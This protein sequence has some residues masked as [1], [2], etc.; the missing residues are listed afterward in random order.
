M[1]GIDSALAPLVS[2][3]VDLRDFEF[4][5]LDVVRL[6]ESEFAAS[7][8]ADE[9]RAGT[10]LWCAAWHQVPASSLPNSDSLLTGLAGLGRDRAAWAVVKDGALHGFVLCSDGRLYHP[11][12]AEKALIAWAGRTKRRAK[13][14]AAA[15]ARWRG[16][17][18]SMPGECQVESRESIEG[19]IHSGS[20]SLGKGL[21]VSGE[22]RGAP[23][24]KVVPIASATTKARVEG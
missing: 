1:R 21:S 13:S 20:D 19:R 23:R 22:S 5:P 16:H 24:G 14:A 8:S 6:R 4:M 7:A 12:I 11:V 17:A 9:F 18:T 10:L 3:E 15:A 2:S